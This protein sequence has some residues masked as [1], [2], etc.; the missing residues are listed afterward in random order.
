[1][2]ICMYVCVES[3]DSEEDGGEEEAEPEAEGDDDGVSG[4]AAPSVGSLL[5]RNKLIFTFSFMLSTRDYAN[6]IILIVVIIIIPLSLAD[7]FLGLL[8]RPL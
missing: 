5:R 2:H 1:M 8:H 4:S 3:T 7:S 6:I